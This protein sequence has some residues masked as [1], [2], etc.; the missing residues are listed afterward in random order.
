MKHCMYLT[1]LIHELYGIDLNSD[2]FIN[3]IKVSRKSISYFFFFKIPIVVA[4]KIPVP[5]CYDVPRVDCF[6]VL[7]PVPDLHCHPK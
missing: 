5:K 7:K 2:Q 3:I 1:I 4:E 6:H